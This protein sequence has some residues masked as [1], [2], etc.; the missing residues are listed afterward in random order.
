M[1]EESNIV[2][3]AVRELRREREKVQPLPVNRKPEGPQ[4]VFHPLSDEE[5]LK[6]RGVN[7][8]NP[9]NA[10]ML[11]LRD[12]LKPFQD[13]NKKQVDLKEAE[14]HWPLIPQCES[15]LELY[16]KD[17]SEMAAELWGHLVGACQDIARS[18]A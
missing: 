3:D 7:P 12:A 5:I 14:L 15:A 6:G 2:L 13:R 8:K 4:A 1:L 11:R 16:G 10:E 9:E 17:K 18:V